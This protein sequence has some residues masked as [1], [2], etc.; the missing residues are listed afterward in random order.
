VIAAS[1]DEGTEEPEFDFLAL[2]QLFGGS[3]VEAE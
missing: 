3:R 1:G 2:V